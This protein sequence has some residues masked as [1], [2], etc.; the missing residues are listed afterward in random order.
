MRT[1]I[2]CLVVLVAGSL[3]AGACSQTCAANTLVVDLRFSGD[4][5]QLD[6]FDVLVT[7]VDQDNNPVGSPMTSNFAKSP[8]ANTGSIE[9]DFPNGYPAFGTVTV[10]VTGTNDNGDLVGAAGSVVIDQTCVIAEL[11]VSSVVG[12]SSGGTDGGT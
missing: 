3:L 6:N 4:A 1:F 2:A 12:A 5:L 10:Q 11:N 8:G 7:I 9:I